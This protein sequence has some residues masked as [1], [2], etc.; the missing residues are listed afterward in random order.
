[1]SEIPKQSIYR[2]RNADIETYL[3]IVD[4]ENMK[5]L[6]LEQLQLTTNFRSVPSILRFVDS[7]FSGV[8][9]PPSDGRIS[10]TILPFGNSGGRLEESVP[11][12]GPPPWGQ[13]GR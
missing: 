8:M 5:S 1:M 10:P 11:A 3:G 4:P 7:A 12:L 6:G 9:K 2:F 13:G